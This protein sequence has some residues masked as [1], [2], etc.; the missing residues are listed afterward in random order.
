MVVAEID[1]GGQLEVTDA[2]TIEAEMIERRR[3]NYIRIW[4]E[5]RAAGYKF[6]APLSQP[7]AQEK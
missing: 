6:R 4:T 1:F 3:I 5:L 2:D 7:T